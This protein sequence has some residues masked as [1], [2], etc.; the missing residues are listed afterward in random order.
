MHYAAKWSF[1]SNKL[2]CNG[3]LICILYSPV[4]MS[5]RS[6]NN[7]ISYLFKY[8]VLWLIF[9]I[10]KL[11]RWCCCDGSSR[12][13]ELSW[14]FLRHPRDGV[15]S[16]G[17]ALPKLEPFCFTKSA[18]GGWNGSCLGSRGLVLL[19]VKYYRGES[20]DGAIVVALNSCKA[21]QDFSS[22]CYYVDR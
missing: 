10:Q 3:A 5:W 17:W 20:I 4:S 19:P 22:F 13:Y 15:T 21:L 2:P 12:N 6:K 11:R 7:F 16:A 8:I 14:K 1:V 9:F 18:L